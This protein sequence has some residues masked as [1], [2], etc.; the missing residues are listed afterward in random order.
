MIDREQFAA[1]LARV[2]GIRIDADDP[3]LVAAL[4][5]QRL[6]D[7]AIGRLEAAVRASADRITAAATQHIEGAREIAAAV[8]ARAGE[9]SAER[10]QVA[11]DEAGRS[12]LGQIRKEVA[13][14]E[15][16][17]RIAV[18]ITWISGA[19]SAV[20]LAGIAGFL[21]AGFGHG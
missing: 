3:V 20:A 12:L 18:R 6:L 17:S 21:L 8:V 13:K 2:H 19:V 1:E 14:A 5:N 9:W 7:E 11:A 4:L 16:A 15:R 10:L